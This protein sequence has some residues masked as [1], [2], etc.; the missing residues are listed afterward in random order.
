[1]GVVAVYAL[2]DEFKAIQREHQNGMSRASTYL[3]A[4][5]LLVLPILFAFAIAAMVIPA[6][7][8][9][10]NPWSTFGL[11]IILYA[12]IAFV[13]E[14][15][16]ETLSVLFVDPIL[17]MLCFMMFWFA[18]FLFGGF[19]IP[20]DD[21][22]WP[23]KAFYYILPF[24]YYMRSAMY[25]VITETDWEQIPDDPTSDLSNV[26]AAIKIVNA[27]FPLIENEDRVWQDIFT[28]LAMGVFWKL[29]YISL[30]I[31]T[32]KK[33]ASIQKSV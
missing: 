22:T 30:F 4:K 27:A 18:C 29:V 2:N 19:L 24:G 15:V 33:V 20:L 13:F 16:A 7:V 31:T 26:E 28:L 1:M 12:T 6:Y 8:I 25:L 32:T 14:S 11:M 3:L 21:M 17:G 9:Q 23:F 10:A 5:S